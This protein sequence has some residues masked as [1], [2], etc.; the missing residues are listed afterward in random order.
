MPSPK[1]MKQWNEQ[2][3]FTI[4]KDISKASENVSSMLG[5]KRSTLEILRQTIL[6]PQLVL[7]LAIIGDLVSASDC[8]DWM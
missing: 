6:S 3:V 5:Q 1:K 2:R 7:V 4:G 8:I